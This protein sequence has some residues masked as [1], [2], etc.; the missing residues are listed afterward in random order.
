MAHDELRVDDGDP[1]AEAE[2][3]TLVIMAISRLL[4][5]MSART[6]AGMDES[7]TLPQLRT[8]VVLE[9]SGP[10][11]LVALAG[12]LDVNPSTAMRMVERLEAAGLAGRKANPANRREVTVRLTERGSS[13]VGAVMTRRRGEVAALVSRLTPRERAGLLPGLRALATAADDLGLTV[14]GARWPATGEAGDRLPFG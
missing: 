8:L 4:V 10:L 14:K 3:I 12:M 11:K 1:A 7:L 13:L 6:L 2:E 9:D 5:G